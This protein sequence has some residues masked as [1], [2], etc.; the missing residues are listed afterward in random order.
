MQ[1]L[2]PNQSKVQHYLRGKVLTLI[3]VWLSLLLTLLLLELQVT[4]VKHS[5]SELVDGHL[6][7]ITEA[8]NVNSSL[9]L[10]ENIFHFN[11]EDVL[12]QSNY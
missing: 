4:V 3:A 8:Q 10:E 11:H 9:Y 7:F 1:F 2:N 6:L 12:L 5:T